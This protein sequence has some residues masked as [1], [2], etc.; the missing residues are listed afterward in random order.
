MVNTRR[1]AEQ[2]AAW[3]KRTHPDDETYR[4]SPETIYRSR[5]NSP[6]CVRDGFQ[7][8]AFDTNDVADHTSLAN[9]VAAP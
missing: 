1:S 2:I 9:Q 6:A 4:V 5:F 3:L 8:R 7:F